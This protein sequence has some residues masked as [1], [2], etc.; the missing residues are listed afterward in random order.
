VKRAIELFDELSVDRV[1]PRPVERE[2]GDPAVAGF[3]SDETQA[4]LRAK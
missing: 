1:R 4:V 2:N 3:C